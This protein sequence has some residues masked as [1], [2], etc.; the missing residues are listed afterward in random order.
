[1]KF[2]L[3]KLNAHLKRYL[4]SSLYTFIGA[5]LISI[6]AMW[7]QLNQNV[8]DMATI[9]SVIA[10]ALRAA[11]KVTGE[12]LLP[13]LIEYVKSKLASLKKK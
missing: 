3:P 4:I 5:F 8:F 2:K 11:I 12:Y 7:G 10:A 9:I 6:W 13:N 1:M